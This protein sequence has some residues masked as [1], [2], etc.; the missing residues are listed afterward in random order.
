MKASKASNSTVNNLQ[1]YKTPKARSLAFNWFCHVNKCGGCERQAE[2]ASACV[3]LWLY[4]PYG[5]KVCEGRKQK[6]SFHAVAYA[7]FSVCLLAL[8]GWV[9][10]LSGFRALSVVVCLFLFVSVWAV[11]VV[12]YRLRVIDRLRAIRKTGRGGMRPNGVR[13]V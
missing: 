3:R 5:V 2:R 12:L 13:Q 9:A 11:S 4:Q 8:V 7:V 10:L 6:K 1:F